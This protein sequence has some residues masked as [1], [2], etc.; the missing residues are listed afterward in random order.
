MLGEGS[1]E[2][3]AEDDTPEH[4]AELLARATAYLPELEG[5]AVEPVPVGYR[6]MP[7]DGM[8]VLGYARAVP[9]LYVALMHSGITLAPL[10]GELAA[11]EILDNARIDL[12]DH[13]RPERFN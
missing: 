2:S 11:M 6:P 10:I 13:Y 1:Q 12:L 3:L 5:A 9:N 4:A 7:I 8:P